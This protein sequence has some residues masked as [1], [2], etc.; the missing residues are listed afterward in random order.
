[1]QA[2]PAAIIPGAEL[3]D[4]PPIVTPGRRRRLLDCKES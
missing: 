4:A 1:M 2:A 3:P